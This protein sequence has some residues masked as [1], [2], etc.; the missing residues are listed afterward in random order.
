[1][2]MRYLGNLYREVGLNSAARMYACCAAVLANQSNDID[3][4]AQIPL[5]FFEAAQAAQIAGCWIDGAGLTEI[6]L[7]AQNLFVTDPFDMDEH[8]ELETSEANEFL[9]LSMVRAF[10]PELLAL[11]EQA[12]PRS[13]WFQH[14]TEMH[15][16]NQI[17]LTLTESQFQ[18]LA[19]AQITSPVFSDI[20]PQ[21]II[22]FRALGVRWVLTFDNDRITVL[23]SEG[24]C[25]G[26]QVLLADI[27]RFHPVLICRTVRVTVQVPTGSTHAV[28]DVRIDAS[29]IEVMA[30]VTL[31]PDVTDFDEVARSVVSGAFSLVAEAHVRPPKELQALLDPL[32]RE[33]LLHK[34]TVVRPYQDAADVLGD[35]HYARCAAA[36]RPMSS[37]RFVPVENEHLAPSTRT[38][39]GYDLAEALE[40]IRQRYEVA[41]KA[42]RYSI[43]KFLSDPRGRQAVEALQADGWLDWQILV[44]IVN[45]GMNWRFE[46][47]GLPPD[48]T[49]AQRAREIGTYAEDAAGPHLPAEL[50]LN[51]LDLHLQMQTMSVA[52]RWKLRPVNDKRHENSMRHLLVRRYHYAHDDLPHVPLLDAVGEG[53]ALLPLVEDA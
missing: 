30:S 35:D 13:G 29:G 20:G 41:H 33:G 4:K 7:M 26:L 46:K 19:Y 34:V 12:H 39:P 49:T 43:G 28:D 53:G 40:L 25:A 6:A 44:A 48:F 23:T 15:E 2:T 18:E 51:E 1:M 42:W 27:A 21:R 38:G 47:D 31:S 24:F 9:Q 52:Q 10:W 5:A 32:M 11:F 16:V 50:I 17:P 37:N 22:D 14:L 45:V 8:P 36:A 3:T